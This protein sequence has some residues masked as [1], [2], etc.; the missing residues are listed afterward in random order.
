MGSVFLTIVGAANSG[1]RCATYGSPNQLQTY[2]TI[3][4]ND[5]W[6]DSGNDFKMKQTSFPNR[7]PS[8]TNPI[9]LRTPD[10]LCFLYVF[11]RQPD[12]EVH[13]VPSNRIKINAKPMLAKVTQ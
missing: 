7:A 9:I 1:D 5:G 12:F 4:K 6:E 10:N 11:D 8:Y 3:H 2:E 13:K